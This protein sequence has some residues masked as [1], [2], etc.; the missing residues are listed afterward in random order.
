MVLITHLK[1]KHLVAQRV[2]DPGSTAAQVTA[3]AR[4][5]SLAQELPHAVG[6]ANKHKH[7]TKKTK[8]SEIGHRFGKPQSRFPVE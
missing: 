2:K 7:K 3:V 5:Q 4:V 1:Y 8:G 6:E